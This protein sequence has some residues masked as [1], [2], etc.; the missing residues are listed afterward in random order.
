MFVAA[1]V[2]EQFTRDLDVVPCLSTID[3]IEHI[4]VALAFDR[5]TQPFI[6]HVKK[7]V[8]RFGVRGGN[9]KV[10]NLAEKNNLIDMDITGVKAGLVGCRN[11]ANFTQ[12]RICMFLL[13]TRG[14]RMTL[15]S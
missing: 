1:F 8:R 11:Q 6:Q 2:N 10:V 15:H 4:K 12:D 9:G 14:L 3:T 7:D 5:D 13:K